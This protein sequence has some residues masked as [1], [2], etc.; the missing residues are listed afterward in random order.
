MPCSS[1]EQLA[2]GEVPQRKKRFGPVTSRYSTCSCTYPQP[3]MNPRFRTGTIT[4]WQWKAYW[5]GILCSTVRE[6]HNEIVAVRTILR[7][8]PWLVEAIKFFIGKLESLAITGYLLI[9]QL[10][11]T[12]EEEPFVP[13]IC[14]EIWNI[15][16]KCSERNSSAIKLT[17]TR[18][19]RQGVTQVT[20]RLNWATLT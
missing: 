17:W 9:H 11:Y 16:Q 1:V 12:V 20:F 14:L 18:V 2:E 3:E 13:W 15:V 7:P 4:G 8:F 5:F 10:V 19:L 6:E